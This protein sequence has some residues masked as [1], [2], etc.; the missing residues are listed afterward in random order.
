M[1]EVHEKEKYKSIPFIDVL[2]MYGIVRFK[3]YMYLYFWMIVN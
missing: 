2:Q 1:Q 3:K